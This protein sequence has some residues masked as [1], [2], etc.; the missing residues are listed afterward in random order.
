MRSVF[1]TWLNGL[2]WN[3]TEAGDQQFLE[4]MKLSAARF[5]MH[6][7]ATANSLYDKADKLAGGSSQDSASY[8]RLVELVDFCEAYALRCSVS[9]VSLVPVVPLVPKAGGGVEESPRSEVKEGEVKDEMV[10]DAKKK[11]QRERLDQVDPHATRS[12]TRAQQKQQKQAPMETDEKMHPAEPPNNEEAK[13]RLPSA[14]PVNEQGLRVT[15]EEEEAKM[16]QATPPVS[17]QSLRGTEQESNAPKETNSQLYIP[18]RVLA[19]KTVFEAAAGNNSSRWHDRYLILWEGY[20]PAEATWEPTPFFD[21][22]RGFCW[23]VFGSS[24]SCCKG[25]CCSQEWPELVVQYQSQRVPERIVA[26]RQVQ[27]AWLY[28]VQWVRK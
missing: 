5:Q 4:E 26:S 11:N 16:Q 8:G 19:K 12:R 10:D 15:E 23:L 13:M 24:D 3:K 9:V 17:G 28:E 25:H 27:M 2:P 21:E 7:L 22:V 20:S 18:Q 14:P 6:S 1:V